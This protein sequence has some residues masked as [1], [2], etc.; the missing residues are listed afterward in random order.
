MKGRGES[1][2]VAFYRPG[3]SQD[4][5]EGTFD[6]PVLGA[7]SPP[8]ELRKEGPGFT[9]YNTQTGERLC[10]GPRK[11]CRHPVG[12]P[13]PGSVVVRSSGHGMLRREETSVVPL[14]GLFERVKCLDDGQGTLGGMN[15]G[16]YVVR[17]RATGQL[18]VEK[19]YNGAAPHLVPLV[20]SEIRMMKDLI[21]GSIIHYVSSF[22]Q[23]SPFRATVYMVGIRSPRILRQGR[24]VYIK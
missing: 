2:R 19:N 10:R 14:H 21:H 11:V 15:D 18:F 12:K 9:Y 7:L 4:D 23:D 17:H 22:I 24:R 13:P 5:K 3:G 8:W 6:H 20:K 16:I 1:N